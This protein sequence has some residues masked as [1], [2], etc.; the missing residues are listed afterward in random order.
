VG[1]P[2][3]QPRTLKRWFGTLQVP[4]DDA[5]AASKALGGTINDLF[6]AG[7]LAGATAYHHERDAHPDRLR[8]AMPVS[9]RRGGTMGG[10]SFA[11]TTTDMAA[12]TDPVE[13]FAAVH[14]GLAAVK[15]GGSTDLVGQLAM[16]VNLL[17]TS[18]LTAFAKD[19]A[20]TVDFTVSNVRG[21]P[22]ELYIAG[23]RCDAVYPMGPIS[24]TGFNLTTLSYAGSLDMGLVVDAG[25]VDDP[26]ALRD[27]LERAYRELLTVS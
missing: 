13:A 8:V 16:V 19:A 23:A 22:F 20:S 18:V 9:T 11:I 3:W 1:S 15:G 10:N 21:A 4:F 14:E 24:G 2:L 12:L 17:P 25:A 5:R 27:H 7:A 26:P 6:V